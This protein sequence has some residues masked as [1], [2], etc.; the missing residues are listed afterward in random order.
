MNVPRFL[1]SA[2]THVST[3]RGATCA[4]VQWDIHLHSRQ[5]HVKVM[6]PIIQQANTC[7]LT[8]DSAQWDANL[9]SRSMGYIHFY[10][11]VTFVNHVTSPK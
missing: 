9:P 4:S 1:R 11:I 10:T 2:A 7:N 3:V 8:S 6:L 5:T